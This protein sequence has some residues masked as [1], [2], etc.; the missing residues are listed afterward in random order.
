MVANLPQTWFHPR[1]WRVSFGGLSRPVNW[2]K[3]T[4]VLAMQL[5]LILTRPVAASTFEA[6]GIGITMGIT[7]HNLLFEHT[8]A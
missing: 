6:F 8:D 2:F 3:E 4:C 5:C 1:Q 7:L